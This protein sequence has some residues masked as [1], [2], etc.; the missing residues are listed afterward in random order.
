MILL[1][2]IF[3]NILNNKKLINLIICND[4]I[5]EKNYLNSK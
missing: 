2:I 4:V 3:K 5:E 1:N